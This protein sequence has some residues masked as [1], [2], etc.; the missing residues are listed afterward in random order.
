[1]RLTDSTKRIWLCEPEREHTPKHREQK[2][3][4]NV[5]F[6][7]KRK[8]HEATGAVF[9]LPSRKVTVMA[10]QSSNGGGGFSLLN[11]I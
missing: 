11:L 6:P 3:N 2:N 7:V 5:D 10:V 4:R 1:M 8:T 9:P